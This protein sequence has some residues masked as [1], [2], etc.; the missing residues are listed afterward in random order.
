MLQKLYFLSV[1]AVIFADK[2]R[3]ND[4]TVYKVVPKDEDGLLYLKKLYMEPGALTFWSV[5]N[6]IGNDVS[7]LA[8]PEAKEDFVAALIEK[9]IN[10][11]VVT[12]NVQED[13]DAQT[14]IRRKRSTSRN[15]IFYDEFN[16]LEDIY[17]YFDHLAETYDF[18]STFVVGTS[19]EGRNIT[20]LRIART[21]SRR[22]FILQ[23]G[24][25]G[26]DWLSPTLVTYLADQLIKG[27]DPEAL[28]ASQD[29]E[30]HIIPVVNPDGFEYTQNHDRLWTKN[31]RIDNRNPTGVDVV[32]NWNSHWGIFGGSFVNTDFNYI[33][34]GPF[35][36]PETRAVSSYIVSLGP[37]V[38]GLLS[39]RMFGQRFLIPFAQSQSGNY[40]NEEM[41]TIARRS[42]G[43]LAVKYNTLYLAGTSNLFWD[44]STGTIGDWVKYR[45]NP[46]IVGTYLLRGNTFVL[47]I[48][49]VLPSCE[50]TF[51]SVMAIFR[52]ARFID[53]L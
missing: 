22:V 52:E 49:Q 26:A 29:F 11:D 30:W 37:R 4:Y 25:I 33:G 48:T 14:I 13:L 18:V 20:G 44:G 27:E 51:D 40:N 31:R 46:P 7:V 3:Y 28:A 19:F 2:V 42:L 39:F 41:I 50:E 12:Q 38:T 24:E 17:S 9:N 6:V 35:S 34:L 8:S 43:S 47:P 32:R 5:P 1:L 21:S 10:V 45:F 16:T 36:E 53:V 15:E 23:G